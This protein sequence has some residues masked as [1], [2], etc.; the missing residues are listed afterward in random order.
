MAS[1]L[2]KAFGLIIYPKFPFRRN[3]PGAFSAMRCENVRG[4]AIYGM[5]FTEKFRGH[6]GLLAGYR[7]VRE[8][9]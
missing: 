6:H 2:K 8:C 9:Y 3:R 5:P 1:L 4:F 7:L